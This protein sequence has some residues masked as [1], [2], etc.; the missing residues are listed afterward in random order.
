MPSNIISTSPKKSVA[1]SERVE[2]ASG[3]FDYIEAPMVTIHRKELGNKS[4]GQIPSNIT[5]N[6]ILKGQ[7][8]G[9]IFIT[10]G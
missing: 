4:I 1:S 9:P 7:S 2:K 3:N 8:A 6:G 5:P 10:S